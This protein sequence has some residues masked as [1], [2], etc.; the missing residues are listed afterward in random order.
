MTFIELFAQLLF[1]VIFQTVWFSSHILILRF[2]YEEII[3][4]SECVLSLYYVHGSVHR[5]SLS[6]IIQQSATIYSLIIFPA[7]SSTCFG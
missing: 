6:I 1:T 5:E 2:T 4:Y 3:I 7:D